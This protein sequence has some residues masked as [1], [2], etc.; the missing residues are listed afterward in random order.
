MKDEESLQFALQAEWAQWL[1]RHHADL[2]ILPPAGNVRPIV[3]A[4]APSRFTNRKEQQK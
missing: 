3:Y 1:T 2:A 4:M